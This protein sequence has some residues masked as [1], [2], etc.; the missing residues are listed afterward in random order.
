M[1]IRE[2]INVKD[3]IL[4]KKSREVTE[5]TPRILTLLD[6]MRETLGL[7]CGVGLAAV[8]V[9]VLRRIAIIDVLNEETE[10]IIELINPE[11][12]LEEGEQT[13]VEGCLSLPGEYGIVTRPQ[14]VRVRYQNRDGELCE[15]EGEDLTARAICHELDHLDGII[16][17]DIAESM[18]TEEEATEYDRP[19]KSE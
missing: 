13:G 5:I 2:I 17:T 18:L 19:D 1:G 14:K 10:E 12:I 15:F 7:V 8:Q 3:P 4:R 6:D 16:Y 9:G 11:I